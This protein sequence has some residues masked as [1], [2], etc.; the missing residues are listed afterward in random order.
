MLLFFFFFTI[1]INP[2][3]IIPSPPCDKTVSTGGQLNLIS[4][5]Q[6]NQR[7]LIGFCPARMSYLRSTCSKTHW[8]LGVQLHLRALEM[9]PEKSA[10]NL[11]LRI[12]SFYGKSNTPD[13]HPLDAFR[14]SYLATLGSNVNNDITVW[15]TRNLVENRSWSD[16]HTLHQFFI[17]LLH[18][19]A[20]TDKSKV[21]NWNLI[22]KNS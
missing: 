22:T 17:H 3:D 16:S 15:V 13:F 2:Q 19:I 1:V 8:R 7:W 6:S 4:C 14:E 21:W 9:C 5:I 18:E 20:M 11:T 10:G 12:V